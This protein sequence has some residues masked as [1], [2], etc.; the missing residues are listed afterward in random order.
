MR[1]FHIRADGYTELDAF[2]DE[3]PTAGFL[4]AASG[5]REFEVAQGDV[6]AALQRLA[7]GQLV[8][9]H[10]ADLLNNQLPSHFDYTSWY[11]F[12]VFR[13]LAAGV[14]AEEL[15]VDDS[16]GTAASARRAPN[17]AK[18]WSRLPPKKN[19]S[20]LVAPTITGIFDQAPAL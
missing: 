12:L 7:G 15:F 3:P 9:L 6:Q 14:G 13:R 16:H 10:V 5:R 1:I 20:A 11:D 2:P 18:T 8:D 19:P 17:G 4:W